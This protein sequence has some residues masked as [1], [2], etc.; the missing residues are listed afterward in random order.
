MSLRLHVTAHTTKGDMR[1]RSALL[2]TLDQ[3]AWNDRV[4][5]QLRRRVF[6]HMAAFEREAC[7]AILHRNARAGNHDARTPTGVIRLNERHHVAVA[8]G[9]AEQDRATG[10]RRAVLEVLRAR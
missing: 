3:H 7:A 10:L 6:V 5:R 8:I 9:G 4:I 1:Q 2:I